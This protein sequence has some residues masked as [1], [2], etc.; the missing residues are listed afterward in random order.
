MEERVERD[1]MRGHIRIRRSWVIIIFIGI[2]IFCFGFK[3]HKIFLEGFGA[4]ISA[5]ALSCGVSGVIIRKMR[6]KKGKRYD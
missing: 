4:F 6:Y 5:G 1:T 3:K 2:V